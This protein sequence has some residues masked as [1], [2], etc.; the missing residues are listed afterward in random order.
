MRGSR[1]GGAPLRLVP[2]KQLKAQRDTKPVPEIADVDPLR[3]AFVPRHLRDAATD[4]QG[5]MVAARDWRDEVRTLP[6]RAEI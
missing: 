4:D 1:S 5:R 3:P 2:C 6:G